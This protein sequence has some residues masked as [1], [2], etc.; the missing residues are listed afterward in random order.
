MEAKTPVLPA[1]SRRQFIFGSAVG[2]LT[3]L[4]C[5][6][7]RQGAVAAFADE[8][9][10]TSF[11]VIV[12][13]RG[14]ISVLSLNPEDKTVVPNM[15]VKLTSQ[16]DG[17][18]VE[19]LTLKTNEA[20]IATCYARDMAE[21]ADAES[22]MG[23]Y[24]FWASVEAKSA[25]Y[26]DFVCP[27]MR[28]QTGPGVVDPATGARQANLFIPSQPYNS[29][30]DFGY[31]RELSFNGF[32]VQYYT[33]TFIAS[34]GNDY[35]HCLRLQLV[36][37]NGKKAKASFVYGGEELGS[38]SANFG[39]DGIA[40]MEIKGQFLNNLETGKETQ[41]FFWVDDA[42]FET[43]VNLGFL[44][45]AANLT[46]EQDREN[47]SI[48][49]G[50]PGEDVN[51][52]AEDSLS[53]A[54]LQ[55]YR[56][57]LPEKLPIA[58][59]TY[60]DVPLPASIV[61]FTMDP[62]GMFSLGI[63]LDLRPKIPAMKK[64]DKENK[65]KV[66]RKESW[67]D[68]RI[69]HFSDE[70]DAIKR[71]DDARAINKGESKEGKQR[72]FG[73]L[74]FAFEF[75]AM[76]QG[77]WEWGSNTWSVGGNFALLFGLDYEWGMQLSIGPCPVYVGFDI[78]YKS[79][80]ALYIGWAMDGLFHNFR[81]KPD[82][83]GVTWLNRFDLGLSAGVGVKGYMSLGVRGYGYIQCVLGFVITDKPFPHVSG[84]VGAFVTAV[85]QVLLCSG[86]VGLYNINKPE[87]WNNWP[88]DSL[89][90]NDSPFEIPSALQNSK[91]TYFLEEGQSFDLVNNPPAMITRT[92][93]LKLAEFNASFDEKETGEGATELSLNTTYSHLNATGDSVAGFG[94]VGSNTLIERG[95]NDPELGIVPA[96]DK[97]IYENILCDSRHKV[98]KSLN[99]SWYLFRLSIV[100]I[101]SYSTTNA[102]TERYFKF[103][104]TSG[105]FEKQENP[106]T[107]EEL[108]E[109]F[110]V[111]R[112]RVTVS[113]MSGLGTWDNTQIIDFP[114]DEE[115]IDRVNCNDYDFA[116]CEDLMSAGTFYL[117]IVSGALVDEA[118]DSFRKRWE[119]QF[120]CHVTYK[121]SNAGSGW[122]AESKSL[123]AEFSGK[124][125]YSP[126]VH[127]L[128]SKNSPW[129]S[130]VSA[131]VTGD[132][133]VY[134]LNSR[135]YN[136]GQLG[137]PLASNSHKIYGE[138]KHPICQDFYAEKGPNWS[139]DSG[140]ANLSWV[141]P[142]DA[143]NSW[144]VFNHRFNIDT[145]EISIDTVEKYT[146]STCP[147]VIPEKGWIISSTKDDRNGKQVD[148]RSGE[149]R[150]MT[151]CMPGGPWGLIQK[152]TV[153]IAN[154]TSFAASS[155]GSRLFAIH[156]EEGS[157]PSTAAQDLN[158]GVDSEVVGVKEGESTDVKIYNIYAANWD[159]KRQTYHTFYPFCQTTHPMD[160]VDAT[161]VGSGQVTFVSTE[162]TNSEAGTGTIYQTNVPLVCS[163]QLT[164]ASAM[165]VFCGPGDT[166]HVSVCVQN[167]GNL[168]VKA[169]TVELYDN[170]AGTG[171]PVAT[172]T[173]TDLSTSAFSSLSD[174][175][176]DDENGNPIHVPAEVHVAQTNEMA[177]VAS[178]LTATDLNS[179]LWPGDEK[180]FGT[181]DFTIPESWGERDDRNNLKV[182]AFV[183]NCQSDDDTVND[184]FNQASPAASSASTAS[185]NSNTNF[186]TAG[187]V[188]A[189]N[190]GVF[191]DTDA[192]PEEITLNMNNTQSAKTE[193]V[194]LSTYTPVN[195]EAKALAKAGRIPKTGDDTS[196]LMGPLAVV[197]AG[198]AAM[199][200]YSNRRFE[201][202]IARAAHKGKH[203]KA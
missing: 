90:S 117:N 41:V 101:N 62:L 67:D 176:G 155:D 36:A 88:E 89:S 3:F 103:N 118:Q 190:L 105:L 137:A 37:P 84:G 65:W 129:F 19:E 85:W 177:S 153:G 186:V 12:L 8:E 121:V 165:D 142:L 69:R 29:T 20:G 96:I 158:P 110:K 39:S 22:P 167:N 77:E 76:A 200:A 1:V 173:F 128:P 191:F 182:Y 169:F 35:E 46:G 26:R 111:P 201:N 9:G 112:S 86:T 133:A 166:C 25:G 146:D 43:S 99:G 152:T 70:C 180:T 64:F 51:P 23:G 168:P 185:L 187:D 127:F 32:D 171:T 119:S 6:A 199:A 80:L 7:T 52:F 195:E 194:K 59:G 108:S 81:W 134:S 63:S 141:V 136:L 179:L 202:E 162:I 160:V 38:T 115:G 124:P 150:A 104:N 175:Q 102:S 132:E 57:L 48:S 196:I 31:L 5:V 54:S 21:N 145:N 61:S 148:E 131:E 18:K 82:S 126:S 125:A 157:H 28:I 73:G 34:S 30:K 47:I 53:D 143:A 192:E 60:F 56:I 116:V 159:S 95:D 78:H 10:S 149:R 13:G 24:G 87:L 189:G 140:Y 135:I 164:S 147:V 94:I 100:N 120:V 72:R 139:E 93:L 130:W 188:A 91:A 66:M 181:V 58:G 45:A 163:L 40:T 172:H 11:V 174:Y 16:S 151:L 55:W 75:S 71:W 14:D 138:T 97:P 114:I 17:S 27:M 113:K 2:A 50:E 68:Y 109:T 74:D 203:A 33:S 92:D 123:A 156:V 184:C 4:G 122:V 15:D 183:T 198:A 161:S 83:Q 49:P 154:M 44:T 106:L 98:V 79:N 178:T 197:G 144:Q 42:K 170:E 107:D 193:K